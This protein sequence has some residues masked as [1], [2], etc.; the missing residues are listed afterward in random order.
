[1]IIKM[2]LV[3]LIVDKSM[4]DEVLRRFIDFFGFYLVDN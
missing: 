1:M 3:N 2:K 4:V